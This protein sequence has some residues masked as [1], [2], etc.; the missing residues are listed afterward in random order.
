MNYHIPVMLKEC[1]NGLNIKP[2]G[3]YVDLTF[4]GGGHS[5]SIL[6]K[7]SLKGSLYS[8]DVDEDVLK[9][10]DLIKNKSFH[11]IKANFRFFR[12]FLKLNGLEKVD[13]IIADLGVSSHQIDS[14]KRG[15]SFRG[16]NFLDMRMN[17]NLT[18]SAI[19]LLNNYN[20]EKMVNVF[21]KYGEIR[22]SIQ[23]ANSIIKNRTKKKIKTNIDLINIIKSFANR[24]KENKYYSQVFQALRIEINDEINSLKDVLIQSPSS[25][26]DNGRLV[27]ISYHSLEDRLVKNFIKKGNFLGQPEK[28]LYGNEKLFFKS[29]NKKPIRPK[30]EE[31]EN[32]PRARSAKLRI[33]ELI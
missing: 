33:G 8:F 1:I 12:N 23:L 18:F 26:N 4:G 32:N 21:S 19:D 10:V 30:L 3:T 2:D 6:N 9:N 7:L 22:N 25:L 5:K 28:D 15:F 14:D 27:I 29:I 20:L 24:N 17:L 31:I 11:F 16:E 13:G